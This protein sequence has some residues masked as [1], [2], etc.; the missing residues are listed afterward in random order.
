MD[1]SSGN[2]ESLDMNKSPFVLGL[3]P[4][5]PIVIESDDDDVVLPT[6]RKIV[7]PIPFPNLSIVSSP[8]SLL[9][10]EENHSVFKYMLS[11][12][13]EFG[14]AKNFSNFPTSKIIVIS[15]D[16]DENINGSEISNIEDA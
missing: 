11:Y 14:D 3:S 16:D 12:E 13:D 8:T 15:S 5:F 6:G 1:P 4:I 7:L 9:L 2:I 10:N